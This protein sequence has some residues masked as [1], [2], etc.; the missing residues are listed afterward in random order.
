MLTSSPFQTKPFSTQTVPCKE[1]KGGPGHEASSKELRSMR[2]EWR[3][4]YSSGANSS[5]KSTRGGGGGALGATTHPG[6]SRWGRPHTPQ[7]RALGAPGP[8]S[9]RARLGQPY[10]PRGARS[11]GPRIRRGLLCSPGSI[12]SYPLFKLKGT[13]YRFW[14][15][16]ISR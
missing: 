15:C 7:G 5:P 6:G 8:P 1:L 13:T 12:F 4:L 10:T 9:V 11:G 3:L 14:D 2:R 16:G